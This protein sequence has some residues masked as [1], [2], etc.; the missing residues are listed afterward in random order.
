MSMR[1]FRIAILD[2]ARDMR[3]MWL[4]ASGHVEALVVFERRAKS[5]G[6]VLLGDVELAI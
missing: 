2:Q 1:K 4:Y 3:S 6:F 5:E